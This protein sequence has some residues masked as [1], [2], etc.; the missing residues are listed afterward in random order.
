MA[1]PPQ[2]TPAFR[3]YCFRERCLSSDKHQKR[4]PPSKR[5]RQSIADTAA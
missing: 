1:R 3:F 5:K 4:L 2:I